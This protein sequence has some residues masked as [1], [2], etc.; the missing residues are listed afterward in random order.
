MKKLLVGVVCAVLIGAAGL[1]AVSIPL[2]DQI[3]SITAVGLAEASNRLIR[4]ADGH[5]RVLSI[6]RV[7]GTS[8]EMFGIQM[9]VVEYLA[10]V[11]FTKDLWLLEE[12]ITGRKKVVT[13]KPETIFDYP[14]F[15]VKKEI[16]KGDRHH[17]AGSVVLEKT[18]SGW[19][20]VRPRT[21]I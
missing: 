11:Q 8:A 2:S 3:D 1:M 6:K 21:D 16:H 5:L 15:S 19:R 9:Y 14:M 12:A 18:E 17:R 13:E 4:E 7:N 10:E 20:P